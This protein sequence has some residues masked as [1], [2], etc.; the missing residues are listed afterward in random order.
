MSPPLMFSL[1]RGV[2]TRVLLLP[3]LDLTFIINNCEMF[4]N[5]DVDKVEVILLLRKKII[6]G[7]F[8]DVIVFL[9]CI[10][11]NKNYY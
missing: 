5:R 7:S 3:F 8:H 9:V 1:I 4:V 10:I 2:I 11:L 6:T